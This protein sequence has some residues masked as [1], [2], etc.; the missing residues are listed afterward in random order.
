MRGMALLCASFAVVAA[1]AGNA[2]A[3]GG[4]RAAQWSCFVYERIWQRLSTG[5][6]TRGVSSAGPSKRSASTTAA[7]SFPPA[8]L[9]R[10]FAQCL[11]RS[12]TEE[13]PHDCRF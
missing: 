13:W 6:V 9:R 2:L 7:G 5:G 10:R 4:V 12:A 11:E 3:H 1:G 8:G